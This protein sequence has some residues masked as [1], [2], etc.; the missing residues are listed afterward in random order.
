MSGL[1]HRLVAQ[2]EGLQLFESTHS[3]NAQ[4]SPSIYTTYIVR[5]CKYPLGLF[6]SLVGLC[7]KALQLI[8]PGRTVCPAGDQQGKSSLQSLQYSV[9][10]S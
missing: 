4:F 9:R 6:I 3:I 7:A 10:H 2:K 1:C 8:C 5:P